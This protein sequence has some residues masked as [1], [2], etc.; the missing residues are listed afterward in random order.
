METN[1]IR[2]LQAKLRVFAQERDWE[3]YHS[4]KNLT[5][6]LM[7]EAAE[8][9]EHF[10]WQDPHESRMPTTDALREIELE[11][12]DVFIYLIRL[13]DQ[14]GIDLAVAADKKLAINAAKYP[15]AKSRGNA[16][17]YDKL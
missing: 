4:P 5:M 13:A 8:L 9:A 3:K 17:K 16:L 6:A 11:V 2:Q 15:V 10:Q 7:V 12:A 14:L 1:P